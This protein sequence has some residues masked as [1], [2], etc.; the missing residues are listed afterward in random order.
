[1]LLADFRSTIVV[2]LDGRDEEV[3][4]LWCGAAAEFRYLMRAS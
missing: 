1:M 3:L 4:G 2:F